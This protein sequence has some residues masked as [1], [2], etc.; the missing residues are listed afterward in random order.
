VEMAFI[1]AQSRPELEVADFEE[2][3]PR[4]KSE[5]Q[6]MPDPGFDFKAL[7]A[8]YERELI[9]RALARTRGN[10]NR[11]AQLLSLKRTTL[12]EKI[13]RLGIGEF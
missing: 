4:P 3:R 5:A 7:T 11:A 12:I 1:R 8:R 2:V 10:R 9:K 13:R 6:E